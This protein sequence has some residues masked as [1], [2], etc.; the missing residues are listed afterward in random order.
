[1]NLALDTGLVA[2]AF[3]LADEIADPVVGFAQEH[4]TVTI[5]RAVARLFG[6]DGVDELG[7]PLP[8]VL[9]D[10]LGSG[11]GAGM[12][13]P[14]AAACT[15]TGQSPQQ[16]AEAVA[17]R[18]G[19]VGALSELGEDADPVAARELAA[20]LAREGDQRIGSQRA[21]RQELVAEHGDPPT[22]WLYVIVATGNIHEDV[23]RRRPPLRPG[24]MSSR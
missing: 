8:N 14:L 24:P 16:V 9:V 6:V 22:P 10:A 1:M 3:A 13:V 7:V 4:T 2:E 21:R 15:A 20:R 18:G 17:A 19:A 5:E 12:A 23:A 11:L